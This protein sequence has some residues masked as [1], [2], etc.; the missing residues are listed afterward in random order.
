MNACKQ[1]DENLTTRRWNQVPG[2]PVYQYLVECKT[3]AQYAENIKADGIL[4]FIE[5]EM[6]SRI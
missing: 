2:I 4:V 1:P 3:F 6:G 5:N